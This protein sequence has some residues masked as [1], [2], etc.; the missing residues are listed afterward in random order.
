MKEGGRREGVGVRLYYPTQKEVT[1]GKRLSIGHF[2]I[3][4]T[5]NDSM[6]RVKF[7]MKTAS[8]Y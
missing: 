1:V 5:P 3:T 6:Y 4:T 2:L 7:F 8:V